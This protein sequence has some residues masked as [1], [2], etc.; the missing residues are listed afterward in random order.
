MHN[1]YGNFSLPLCCLYGLHLLVSDFAINQLVTLQTLGRNSLG[2]NT[3][4]S[5]PDMS[6]LVLFGMP[7]QAIYLKGGCFLVGF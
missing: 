2:R 3:N 7:E 5:N 4:S 1:R 6:Y